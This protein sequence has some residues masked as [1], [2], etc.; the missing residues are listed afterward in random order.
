M[1]H[2]KKFYLV[3]I[4]MICAGIYVKYNKKNLVHRLVDPGDGSP[5]VMEISEEPAYL[6]DYLVAVLSV[7]ALVTIAIYYTNYKGSSASSSSADYSSPTKSGGTDSVLKSKQISMPQV[8]K[9]N[10]DAIRTGPAN[11]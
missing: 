9:F 6:N 2:A 3:P 11:F 4:A 5:E 7:G 8:S 10:T 1:E